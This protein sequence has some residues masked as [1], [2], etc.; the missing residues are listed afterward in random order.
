MSLND[1]I[2][3]M[4][5]SDCQRSYIALDDEPEVIMNKMKK[6]VSATGKDDKSPAI[7]NLFVLLSQFAEPKVFSKFEKDHQSGQISYKDLKETLAESISEYFADFRTRKKELQKVIGMLNSQIDE[8]KA[9][10][11]TLRNNRFK[12]WKKLP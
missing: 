5:K 6:A 10:S 1:P 7:N 11:V 9:E 8:L 12:F 3:K 2:K 4:S